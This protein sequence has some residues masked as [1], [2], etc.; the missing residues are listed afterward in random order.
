MGYMYPRRNE[1]YFWP[2]EFASSGAIEKS[3]VDD[4]GYGEEMIIDCRV[5]EI[6]DARIAK[7]DF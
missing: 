5:L 7:D 6:A 3:L 2:G 1:T 4:C